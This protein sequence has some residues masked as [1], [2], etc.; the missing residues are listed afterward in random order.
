MAR[1]AGGGK[2]TVESSRT[3][4]VLDW[5]W[6]GYLRSPRWFSWAWTRDGER[7][8]SIN[9]EPQRQAVTLKYRSRS[10]GEDWRDVEQRVAIEWTSCRLGGERP[11]FKCSVAANGVYC[12]RRVIKLYGAGSLFACRHCFGLPTQASR[13]WPI[14]AGLGN[15]KRSECNW[16]EVQTCLRS[17]LTSQ[18]ACTG[19]PRPAL[20]SHS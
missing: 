4:D 20:A 19:G 18:R 16:A 15:R 13:S 2:N 14:S 11:W 8:A 3:I 5:N 6:R 1:Y 10:H 7:L 9:V 12:G 17:F